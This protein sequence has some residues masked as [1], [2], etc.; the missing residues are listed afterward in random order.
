MGLLGEGSELLAVAR[1]ISGAG[2]GPILGGIAVFLHGYQRTTRD[3][4]IFAED[5]PVAA[6]VLESLGAT[7]DATRREHTLDGVPIHIVT[8][9]QTGFVPAG[10]VEIGGIRIVPLADLVAMK[11]AT[12]LSR[13]SRAQDLADVVGLIRAVPLDKAFAAKLPAD[14]RTDFKRLVDAVQTDDNILT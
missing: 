10:S 8:T 12:G 14:L 11:L 1:R 13:P 9:R 4:D 7:W 5:S 3:I 2:A 6:A